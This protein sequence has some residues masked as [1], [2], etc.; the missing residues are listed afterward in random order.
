[1]P[2]PEGLVPLPG[3]YEVEVYDTPVCVGVF[4]EGVSPRTIAVGLPERVHYAFDVQNS[5]LA[6]AWRGRFLDARGTWYARAGQLE[7]PAGEDVLEFPPGNGV[8]MLDQRDD[9]WPPEIGRAAG[10]RV[11]GRR[12]D[13][14]RRP[15]FEYSVCGVRVEETVEP[16]VQ[17]GG[18]ALRRKLSV[19]RQDGL[20]NLFLRVAVGDSIQKLSEEEWLIRGNGELRVR[21]LGRAGYVHDRDPGRMELRIPLGADSVKSEPSVTMDSSPDS[22]KAIFVIEYSW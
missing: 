16:V 22:P 9:P 3:E 5:R 20:A 7:K 17:A 18:A 15:V 8:M 11:I 10:C 21:G 14:A 12:L 6:M 2:L 13:E 19:P 4:M 1:M